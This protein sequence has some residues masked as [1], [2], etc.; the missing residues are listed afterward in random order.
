MVKRIHFRKFLNQKMLRM[1]LERCKNLERISLSHYAF[2]N[3]DK[4][5]LEDLK[6]RGI[7]VI[8]RKTPGRRSL[9]ERII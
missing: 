4:R 5:V 3:C 8:V 7:E 6:R 2:K 1:V 9:V